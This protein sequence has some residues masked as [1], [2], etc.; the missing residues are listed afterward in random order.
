VAD[1]VKGMLTFARQTKPERTIVDINEVIE[2]SLRL[3]A[4]EL[5][6]N[7]IK[8]T[9][10]LAPDLPLTVADPGQLQQVFL[11]LIINAEMEMKL[12]HGKGKLAIK[13]EQID[14]TIRISFRDDGPGI[15][16]ENLE[17]IFDPFF[18]TREAGKGTGLGLSICH[19]IVT[20]HKGR[21]YVESRLGH[22]ATFIIELPIVDERRR[23][24]RAKP[25]RKQ[26]MVAG[27]KILVVDDEPVVRQLLSQVLTDEGH[28]VETTDD[29][30]DALNRI[31]GNS[32]S[33]ILLDMKLPG[34]SG[35]GLYKLI[36]EI[37]PSLAKRVVFVTGDVMGAD[38][39]AFLTRTKLPY[40]A[41][42]FDVHELIAEVNR[43]LARHRPK[44]THQVK[45]QKAK[46]KS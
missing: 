30:K 27:A 23:P 25:A 45:K 38:T 10:N 4:Y 2:V 17:R 8:V 42:P 15:T 11:N 9:T 1:I 16:G 34:I 20:E 22:G 19:G 33:L 40:I 32:Y 5:A 37:E 28:E 35:S 41:K 7:N 29:G 24:K 14:N 43:V 44:R 31:K 6:T 21:T 18:T 26:K 36:Q 46:T 3:R 13:T 12:A 39:E